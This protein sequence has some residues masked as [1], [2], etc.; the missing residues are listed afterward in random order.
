MIVLG[1]RCAIGLR[2]DDEPT[3]RLDCGFAS[4]DR[5]AGQ[6][7]QTA[8]KAVMIWLWPLIAAG[9][10]L[11]HWDDAA[12]HRESIGSA[13][14]RLKQMRPGRQHGLKRQRVRESKT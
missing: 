9:R 8:R 13:E 10:I 14:A 2:N 4:R 12:K 5:S 3:V 7:C 6:C 1:I 11:S